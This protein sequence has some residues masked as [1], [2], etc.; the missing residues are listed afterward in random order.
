M[1]IKAIL[2]RD[3]G[4][5]KTTDIEALSAHL[6]KAFSD[7]GHAIEVDPV[8]GDELIATLER[9]GEDSHIDAIIAGGGDGTISAA[10]GIAWKSGKVMGVLPAGTMNLF[11]RSL[12]V[13]LDLDQA[14][15]GLADGRTIDCDIATA[16][17]QSFVH[18]F[19]VGLQP[20]IVKD[21][22]RNEHGSRLGKLLGGLSATAANLAE[23]PLFR[24]DIACDGLAVENGRAYSVIAVSNNPYGTDMLPYA[25][26]LNRGLLGV[27]RVEN[28]A[29][30]A[31][32]RL[33]ADLV[34]GK[35]NDSEDL[36]FS[37]A[38]EV[39]LTFPEIK[40][41]A[42]ATID[43]ELVPLEAEVE[44]IIHPGA[45]KVLAPAGRTGD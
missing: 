37:M 32:L 30:D 14:V 31:Y 22:E 44:I 1:R 45:L 35:L 2:N 5:L 8:A 11:A 10:A 27:Y 17:G 16:N 36:N 12:H 26:R 38:R 21:R 24:A 9:A 39:N 34:S 41:G 7:A 20:R 3:G 15:T 29:T 6:S 23:P 33:V 25:D 42:L 28:L 4:T 43:G 19:S 18:Q 40:D 13:P